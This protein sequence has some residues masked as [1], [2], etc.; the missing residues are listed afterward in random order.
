[1]S[2]E[3]NV[4]EL[5][6]LEDALKAGES[7]NTPEE[8]AKGAALQVEDLSSIADKYLTEGAKKDLQN[9]AFNTIEVFDDGRVNK[10]AYFSVIVRKG[11]Q[12][13]GIQALAE[14]LNDL[15][16]QGLIKSALTPIASLEL[17]RVPLSVEKTVV[18][19]FVLIPIDSHEAVA[20]KYP[21]IYAL[22]GGIGAEL[23]STKP[24]LT[25]GEFLAEI[26]LSH[27]LSASNEAQDVKA[28]LQERIDQYLA[29]LPKGTQVV[30][31]TECAI[32]SLAY[33]FEV[34][35]Y[36]PLMKKIK[37]VELDHIR[38]VEKIGDSLQEF[39]LLTGIRYFDGDR[40][41]L[42]KQ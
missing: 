32:V 23:E 38:N 31:V 28:R 19:S 34:K 6:V 18:F 36:N 41:E 24:D 42:F 29:V 25:D 17:V 1:M 10:C 39:N 12:E 11:N 27:I 30:S 16:Q 21:K 9:K 7:P 15:S 14:V 13:K 5:Q 35:F 40:Q 2:E 8:L 26:Q 4:E 22:E 3:N 33:P 20:K 37:S